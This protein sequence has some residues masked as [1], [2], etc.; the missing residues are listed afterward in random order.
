MGGGVL[1]QRG[2]ARRDWGPARFQAQHEPRHRTRRGKWR[3]GRPPPPPQTLGLLCPLYCPGLP[4]PC[5]AADACAPLD[6]SPADRVPS[7][8]PPCATRKPPGHRPTCFSIPLKLNQAHSPACG[9][10]EGEC[11]GL[12]GSQRS[13][14]D[15]NRYGIQEKQVW[16]VRLQAISSSQR[17]RRAPVRA[18]L[19]AVRQPSDAASK[20]WA[21]CRDL[22]SFS[23]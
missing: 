2:T 5:A 15:S 3:E 23:C 17:H 9:G 12:Q 13:Q 21:T 14:Q 11:K 16:H 8:H 6:P 7:S 20:F 10:S 4:A 19:R 1:R 22:V 18:N